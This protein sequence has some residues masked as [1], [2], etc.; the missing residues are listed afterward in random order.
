MRAVRLL[1]LVLLALA[2][3]GCLGMS[4]AEI[5][6]KKAELAAKDDEVYRGYGARPGTD[7]YIKCRMAQQKARDDAA[8]MSQPARIPTATDNKRDRPPNRLR[9]GAPRRGSQ[10]ALRACAN[11][12]RLSEKPGASQPGCF[13][14]MNSHAGNSGIRS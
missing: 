10:V 9:L 6:A 13:A 5:A 3:V 2:L 1:C 7:V 11:R 12:D 8:A 14:S 4:R